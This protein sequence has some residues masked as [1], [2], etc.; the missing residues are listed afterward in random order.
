MQSAGYDALIQAMGGVMSLTGEPQGE[1]MKVG[2]S[3]ADLMAGMYACVGI[4]PGASPATDR[5]RSI[6]RYQYA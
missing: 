4:M 1:P 2:V 3:I 6:Y 5:R